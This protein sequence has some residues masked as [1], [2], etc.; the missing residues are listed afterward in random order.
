MRPMGVSTL[1]APVSGPAGETAESEKRC[2][3]FSR[4]SEGAIDDTAVEVDIGIK[5]TGCEVLIGK[6]GSFELLSDFEERIL[7]AELLENAI[8]GL[9]DD[10]GARIVILVNAVTETH[11]AETGS[12]V[13]RH[14]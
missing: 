12:L 13:F 14:D 1:F 9:L 6:S 7:T 8:A 5:F 11:E 10:L 2:E 4:D 3:H